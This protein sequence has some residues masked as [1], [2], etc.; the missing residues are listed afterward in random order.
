MMT[1]LDTP[2]T[3]RANKPELKSTRLKKRLL[4]EMVAGRLKPGLPLPSELRLADKFN[5][6]RVTVRRALSEME[7]EGLV[8]R[9]QGRGTFVS[10]DAQQRLRKSTGTFVL[11]I[12]GAHDVTAHPLLRGFERTCRSVRHNMH[13]CDSDNNIHQQG[14][15][16]LGLLQSDVAGVAILPVSSPFTPPHHITTLQDRGI[17]VICCHRGVDGAETPLLSVAH[18]EEGRLV[19]QA[20]AGQGHRRV[21]LVIGYQVD[22]L[23]NKWV[24]GIRKS[25]QAVDG[26]LPE[27]FV[28]APETTTLDCKKHEVELS[29]A[30]EK[31][32][33]SE[34]PPT[35]IFAITDDFAQSVY[36]LLQRMGLRVP[37]DVSLVGLGD[38]DRKGAFVSRLTS[39]VIDGA[40]MGRQAVELLGQMQNGQREIN[41]SENIPIPVSLSDGQTL[42]PAPK[43]AARYS[44]QN[45]T[46]ED[47]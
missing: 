2:E 43:S 41:N 11:L 13:L 17:P 35:A 24:R 22:E 1:R 4:A 18:E 39:V 29:K 25:L 19:G 44:C 16:I 10:D 12:S 33:A 47:T 32:F 26:E 34:N 30:L 23:R 20:F 40:E 38:I 27:E 8:R 7:N 31:M 45:E 21:A 36:F 3:I 15:L 5:V 9:E 14:D 6:S 28:Y 46:R 37:E 42:G